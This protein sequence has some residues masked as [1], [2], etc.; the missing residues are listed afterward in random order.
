MIGQ[1]PARCRS[2]TIFG[3]V[4]D[5]DSVMEFGFNATQL[6]QQTVYSDRLP[7]FAV[8]YVIIAHVLRCSDFDKERTRRYEDV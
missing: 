4:C 7:S 1:I 8:F 6:M 3:S 5:Q 2:A